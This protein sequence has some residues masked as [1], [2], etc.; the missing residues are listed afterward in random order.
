MDVV[1]LIVLVAALLLGPT[2]LIV[3]FS[4]LVVILGR[5]VLAGSA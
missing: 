1:T 2:P 3:M 5:A 4:S